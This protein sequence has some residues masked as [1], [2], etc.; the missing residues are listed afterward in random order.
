MLKVLRDRPS[1]LI[2]IPYDR[3]VAGF[4]GKTINTLRL[5]AATSPDDFDFRV[6]S[7][8][9]FAGAVAENLMAES[10]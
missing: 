4:G 9:D 8:C 6:F 2:G 7:P 10:L 5:W 3:P 1:T